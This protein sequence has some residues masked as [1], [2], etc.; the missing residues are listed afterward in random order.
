ML[1]DRLDK[2]LLLALLGLLF[3]LF[4]LLHLLIN[5][6]KRVEHGWLRLIRALILNHNFLR[7]AIGDHL[8][9]LALIQIW[10]NSSREHFFK[11]TSD[12]GRHASFEKN[13]VDLLK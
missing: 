3:I 4:F 5:D 2:G 9:D 10:V 1:T 6:H 7:E 12:Y 11:I 8:I 13:Q